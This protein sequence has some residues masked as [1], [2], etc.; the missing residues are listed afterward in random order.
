LEGLPLLFGFYQFLVDGNILFC[1]AAD[2]SFSL[3]QEALQILEIFQ[4]IQ[5]TILL[6]LFLLEYSLQALKLLLQQK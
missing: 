1:Y 6:K 2:V 4:F 3:Q 5:S